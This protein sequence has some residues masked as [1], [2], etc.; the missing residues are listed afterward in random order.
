MPH[1]YPKV[2]VHCVF[3]TKERRNIIPAEIQD[4]L[5][6]YIIGTARKFGINVLATG[7]VA[8]HLHVLMVLPS[9]MSIAK[10]VQTLKANS[11]RWMRE[12]Q[13]LFSWQEGYGAFSVSPSHVGAVKRYIAR[14]PE[15][16]RKRNFEEEFLN[17]L[18][19]AGVDYDPQFVF[20]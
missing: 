9:E 14:Q 16:H 7:G 10:A 6:R 17:L 12:K 8:D 18:R 15:H 2:L 20:G 3:S 19:L 13:P 11:S 4:E 1:S 5:Q